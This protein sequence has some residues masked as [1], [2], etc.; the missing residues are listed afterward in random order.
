MKIVAGSFAVHVEKDAAEF[1]HVVQHGEHLAVSLAFPKEWEW[2]GRQEAVVISCPRL[3]TLATEGTYTVAG[4]P[5]VDKLQAGGTVLVQG[6]RQDSLL[7][8]QERS[9]QI[10]LVGNTLGWL[11]AVVGTSPGSGPELEIGPDNHIQVADLTIGH[12]GR[13][14]LATAIAHL[15]QQFSDSA[16]VTFSGAAARGLGRTQ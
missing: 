8:R 13:L 16:T 7:L 5:Q 10:R 1:V 11:R 15:R 6:F 14:E 3:A 9:N 2:L 4:Q 12:Q